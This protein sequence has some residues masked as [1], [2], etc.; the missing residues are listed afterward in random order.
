MIQTYSIFYYG[1]IVDETNYIVNFKEGAGPEFSAE[2]RNGSYTLTSYAQAVQD[3]LNDAGALDYTVTV[4]R[5][6]RLISV[7]AT[8]VFSLLVL[9][10]SASGISAFPMIGFSGSDRT[11]STSYT[12]NVSSGKSY[13]PQFKLQDYIDS[14]H[15]KQSADK[16]VNKTSSGRIEVVRFGEERFM[17]CN[18]KFI[19]SIPQPNGVIKSNS[20]GLQ[21]AIDFLSYL[22]TKSPIEF[23]GDINNADIFESFILE[24]APDFTDGTGFRLKEL[25]DKGLIDYYET[26][27]L[28]FRVVGV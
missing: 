7:N 22:I 5:A 25:Y 27:V 17:Q 18:I 6:T 8:G 12:G 24:S 1:H 23:I 2:I 20:T 13:I 15:W 16:T 9:S 21:D 26:G 4:D 28:K 11:G 10:G 14:T 3:A 19:T